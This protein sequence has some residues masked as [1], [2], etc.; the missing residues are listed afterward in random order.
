MDIESFYLLLSFIRD[1]IQVDKAQAA[2]HGGMIIPELC[3][4]CT[5]RILLGQ[6][7]LM[8][9]FLLGFPLLLST[10]LF[11]K[12][13]HAINLADELMINFPQT[14]AE[15]RGAAAGFA[16]ISFQSAIAN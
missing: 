11:T 13:I 15:C 10:G 4:Y 8:L 14:M 1:S 7:T 3:L 16:N 2:S 6:V 9:V 5:L 12:T